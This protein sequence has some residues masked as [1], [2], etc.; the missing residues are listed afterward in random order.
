MANPPTLNPGNWGRDQTLFLTV[1]KTGQKDPFVY[2]GKNDKGDFWIWRVEVQDGTEDQE[3]GRERSLFPGDYLHDLLLKLHAQSAIR[4]GS[5]LAITKEA[6]KGSSGHAW[7]V[8]FAGQQPQPSGAS[9]SSQPPAPP[10]APRQPSP[11][12]PAAFDPYRFPQ[13][14]KFATPLYTRTQAE[15]IA[16]WAVKLADT[17]AAPGVIESVEDERMIINTTER[18]WSDERARQSN[19]ATWVILAKEIVPTDFGPGYGPP[20]DLEVAKL[21]FWNLV[22]T[23]GAEF[24]TVG[25]MLIDRFKPENDDGAKLTVW[26]YLTALAEVERI[27]ADALETKDDEPGKDDEVDP[28]V[29]PDSVEDVD[30]RPD[31]LSDAGITDADI[32]FGY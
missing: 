28:N 20:P 11:Q 30:E 19:I 32:P 8:E 23:S 2:A 17:V 12:P 29:D 4:V 15:A 21:Q 13:R 9:V 18:R 5:K 22:R 10:P 16:R 24:A 14:D 31:A 1:T 7:I 3:F 6:K 26:N 27:V 25:L